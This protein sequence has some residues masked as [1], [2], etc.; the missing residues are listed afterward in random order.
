MLFVEF[1]SE[2]FGILIIMVNEQ[3]EATNTPSSLIEQLSKAFLEL[4]AYKNASSNGVPCK[5]IE[6]HF[7]NLELMLKKKSEEVEAKET[8]YKEKEAQTFALIVEREAEVA[9]KEQ[10]FLDRLQE[11]K[12]AAVAAIED[13][14]ANYQ[15]SLVSSDDEDNQDSKV[16]NS[17]GEVN[18][19]EDIPHEI[20]ENDK[21]VDVKPRPELTEFCKQMDAK[22]LL[23]YIMENYKNLYAIR[24]EFS[25]A[26]Q[27]ATEPARLVLDL[28]EGVYPPDETDQS[29][30]KSNAALQGKHKFCAMFIE[31]MAALMA[32]TDPVADHL[33][34]PETSMQAKAIANAWKP[35]LAGTNPA[36]TKLLEAEAFLQLL[37]TFRIASE[38][39]EEEL[40]KLAIVVARRRQAP[41]LCRS[42]G[43]SHKVPG[44][45]S[46]CKLA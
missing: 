29:L 37:A 1:S 21:G 39:D 10:E 20:G 15:Q 34:N 31:G 8:E 46:L 16:S 26:L 19:A 2:A 42:L 9:A 45:C 30:A 28:L 25:V 27:S 18:S 44:W 35:K 13:A 32:R 3:V 23:K 6:E 43:L 12:D 33:L 4:E 38:F 36:N 17:I 14:R 40:C 11:L 7:F 5:E 41:E 22:G 24:K